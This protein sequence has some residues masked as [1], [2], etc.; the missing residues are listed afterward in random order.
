MVIGHEKDTPETM[1]DDVEFVLDMADRYGAIP[2]PYVAK[3]I[4]PGN[5]GWNDPANSKYVE[6]LIR[7]PVYFQALDFAALPCALTHPDTEMHRHIEHAYTMMINVP[8]NTTNM[9]Y[10]IAPEIDQRTA[11][12]HRRLN[13][14]KFDR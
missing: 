13:R 11:E 7:N 6:T 10:P 9:V 12:I 3:S 14:T 1:K 2:R 8:G 5:T 4:I